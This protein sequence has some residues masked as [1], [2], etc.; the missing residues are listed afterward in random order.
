VGLGIT[1]V[2]A[3]NAVAAETTLEHV[4]AP[5]PRAEAVVRGISVTLE[6]TTSRLSSHLRIDICGHDATRLPHGFLLAIEVHATVQSIV[7]RNAE[8][9]IAVRASAESHRA[10]VTLT[11]DPFLPPAPWWVALL[12]RVDGALGAG[13]LLVGSER[14]PLPT[15]LSV[16]RP[17]VVLGPGCD[18]RYARAPAP[19]R[20]GRH[21]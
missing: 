9:G 21:A 16:G 19:G 5:I 15:S 20:G 1:R 18:E 6:E 7:L 17:T 10:T 4:E 12:L 14:Y 2:A 11:R 3:G 13:H 8:A